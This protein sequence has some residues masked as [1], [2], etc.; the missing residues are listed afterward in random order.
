MSRLSFIE[1]HKLSAIGLTI[2]STPTVLNTSSIQSIA[3][4][5]DHCVI[6]L[7]GRDQSSFSVAE[8]YDA[9]LIQINRATGNKLPGR[10]QDAKEVARG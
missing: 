3:K 5:D 7:V 4:Y 9:V 1:V 8:N 2:E 10:V 6:Q